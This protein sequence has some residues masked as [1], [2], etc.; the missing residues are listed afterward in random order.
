VAHLEFAGFLK[1]SATE[2]GFV[3]AIRAVIGEQL[4]P[5]VKEEA[6]RVIKE[7]K[8]LSDRIESQAR[9]TA[10]GVSFAEGQKEFRAAT[11]KD[12][13][14]LI[15]WSLVSILAVCFFYCK[16]IDFKNEALPT[17]WSWQFGYVASI[18]LAI[19]AGIISLAGFAMK[20]LRS[21][22]HMLNHNLH[23]KR[24]SNL[25][26]AFVQAAQTAEQ[27]DAILIRLVDSIV[28]FGQSGLVGGDG[29]PQMPRLSIGQIT[30]SL[31]PSNK[32]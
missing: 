3:G 22:L 7:A 20:N 13:I 15:V 18:R 1:S 4:S 14:Q 29:E 10:A 31:T 11:T 2:S 32:Q 17:Q 30:S 24:V 21:S 27:R 12:W 19:L 26:A 16:A 28:S 9:D 6:D 5:L 25:V 8:A 23:R